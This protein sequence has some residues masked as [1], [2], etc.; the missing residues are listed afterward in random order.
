MLVLFI[1]FIRIALGTAS[2]ALLMSI[3]AE[4]YGLQ[5]LVRSGL[6]VCVV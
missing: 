2:K 6:G 3:V 1:F 4:V 5:V